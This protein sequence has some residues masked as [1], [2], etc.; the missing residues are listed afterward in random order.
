MRPVGGGDVRDPGPGSPATPFTVFLEKLAARCNLTRAEAASALELV[1][2]GCVSESEMAAFLMG[3]RAKGETAEE[4]AGLVEAMRRMVVPVRVA[5][6]EPLV[7]VVGTG[8]DGLGTFNISTTAA[9]VVAAAGVRV[10]KHG[11]RAASSRCG[12]A[13]LLQA[14]GVRIDLDPEDIAACVAE[15]GLGFMPAPRHHPAAG[16]VA[17]VRRALRIRTVFNFL[18]PLTNP[19]GVRRMLLGVS[20]PTF[21][22]LL[23][24]V[25]AHV[26]CD[27][28]L[29]VC[30]HEGMD[31]LSVVG[32]NT[33]VEVREGEVSRSFELD[34]VAYGLGPHPLEALVGGDAAYNAALT[35]AV[36]GGL[37]GAP[38]DAVLLNAG[39]ALYVAGACSS[40]PEGVE[41]ARE[42]L[43]NGRA[44]AVLERLITFTNS[45]R[46]AVDGQ[47]GEKGEVPSPGGRE[48]KRRPA[49]ASARGREEQEGGRRDE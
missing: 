23:A 41:Q 40:I 27:H 49:D 1:A 42:V 7:D 35:R 10:A 17:G 34:P 26:G 29:V 31:E 8:G 11:N 39:A 47:P 3:L 4:I 20:V 25:L 38:R 44:L 14:L 28:A 24:E 16:R 2:E 32:R 37:T 48:A 36:L 46:P 18:G 43:D 22:P 6:A 15:V 33:V 45:R 19:A 9:F 13:D 21:V 12:S 30:G 5:V